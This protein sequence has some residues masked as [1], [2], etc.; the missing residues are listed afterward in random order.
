MSRRVTA[1]LSSAVL[2][3]AFAVPAQAAGPARSEHDRIVAF[4]TAERMASATPRDFTLD[5]KR[6]LPPAAQPV[7]R[8][9]P[10]NGGNVTGASW[11]KG[12]LIK[13]AS[14]KV[15]FTM[16]G[17]TYVCS[18]AV[19][20]DTR[21]NYSLVLTAAHCAY[22]ETDG[23][24]ATNWMFYPDYDESP[25]RTCA[26]T[27]YGCWT[28]SGLVVHQGYTT[29]GGFN[30]QATL[31][32]WAF[33]VV[34]AGGKASTQLDTTVGSFPISF[35]ALADG[36]KV[37]AFGYPA[38]QKYRGND[39]VYCA[40]PTFSD[41]YNDELTYGVTCDMTGGSSGGPW[42]SGFDEGTGSGTL[43]SVN[44]YGYSGVKAMHG[45]KFNTKTQATYSTADS[46]TTNTIASGG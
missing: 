44:S 35:S 19:A 33:A 16:G 10:G 43:S 7:G 31:H 45:P 28:A 36:T 14:G 34:G 39:F 6:G 42:L 5:P 23:A 13:E 17:T 29:A 20:T 15:F 9:K 41:P 38:A 37:Y 2:L 25:T 40:G 30:Q 12:G 22:D 8:A 21:T 18:G 24:F 46:S 27:A 32:D 3:V 26:N 11:T 4:W 1:I